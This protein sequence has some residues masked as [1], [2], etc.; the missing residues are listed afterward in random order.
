[1]P[2]DLLAGRMLTAFR[3]DGLT[4]WIFRDGTSVNEE[5]KDVP[6]HKI[7]AVCAQQSKTQWTSIASRN[8]LYQF[9]ALSD[10]STQNEMRDMVSS[11]INL[12][13]GDTTESVPNGSDSFISSVNRLSE[14][15]DP[16]SAQASELKQRVKKR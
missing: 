9:M 16:M 15:V 6:I 12:N 7:Q 14:T 8:R 2:C 10:E 11:T 5:L 3:R 4:D 13:K 1:M